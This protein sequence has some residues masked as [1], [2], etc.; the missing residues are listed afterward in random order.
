MVDVWLSLQL[1]NF[2]KK[3]LDPELIFTDTDSLTFQIKS[4]DDYEQFFQHKHMSEEKRFDE[5]AGLKSTMYSMKTIDGEESSTW[6]SQQSLMNLMT[7]CSTR[8]Y[9]D[10]KWEEFKPKS[11]NLEHT[12]STKYHYH[13]LMT[14]LFVMKKK[15]FSQIKRIQKIFIKRR[16]FHGQKG[17][18]KSSHEKKIHSQ[19]LTNRNKCVQI[20][21]R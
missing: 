21:S 9:S 17:L 12:K 1:Y 20:N 4:E 5:F 6:I 3:H 14:K 7:L 18:K 13:V 11:I 10:I 8:K 16:D 15:R 2:I 19:I